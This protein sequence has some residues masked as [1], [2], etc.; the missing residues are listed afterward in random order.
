MYSPAIVL[1]SFAALSC[2]LFA[3]APVLDEPLPAV[4]EAARVTPDI[5]V[6]KTLLFP[7]TASDADGDPLSYKVTSTNPNIL[8]RAKTGNP[9]LRMSVSHADGG[10]TDPAFTGTM[11]FMLF[12]DWLPITTG[13]VSGM[14]RAGFY[15]NVL[16]HR[17]ADLG[18]G[19]GT[20]GFIFQGGDPLGSGG[21]GPGMVANDPQSAWKFQNEFHAGT[22][23]SGR[24]QLAMANAGTTTGYSLGGNG[25]LIVPDY[26]DTNGSQFFITDGQPRH[27]DFKHNIFG[28]L[29]RGWE[30]LP[31]LKATKTVSSRPDKDLRILTAGI[32]RNETDAVLVL[33][34]KA[35]GTATISITVCDPSGATATKQF[36]V[37]A[38]PDT[39][40]CNPFLRRN[41]PRVTRK[42]VPSVFALEMVDLEFDYLD[43]QH[44]MLPLSATLGPKGSLLTSSGRV[45][46]MQPN[47]AYE[48][49]VNIGLSLRQYDI[50]RGS[51]DDI[52]DYT[53]AYVAVGERLARAGNA[54]IE[55]Q[56]G[57][58]LVNAV[59]GRIHDLDSAGA[60]SNFT[61]K[62]NWGD[63]TPLSTGTVVRE[64]SAPGSTTYAAQGGHTY[65]QPGVYP[66]VVDF[67][68]NN[69]ARTLSYG[70]AIVSAGPLRAVGEEFDLT[71]GRVVNR[72]VATFTDGAAFSPLAYS[73]TVDWGDGVVSPGVIS[74]DAENGQFVVRGTHGYRDSEPFSVRVRIHKQND[75]PANDAIAWTTITPFFTAPPHLPPFPHG[76]LTVAWNS[77]PN[78]THS[79]VPGPDYQVKYTGTFVI[80]NTGNRNLGASS[81]RFWVS[82]DR[83]L[84]TSGPAK[85][86]PAKINSQRSLGIIPFPAG[87]GG[88][89]QFTITIPKGEST[90]RKYLIGEAVY[91]QPIADADGSGKYVVTGPLP[92]SVLISA[93]TGMIT[94]EFGGTATFTVSFDTPPETTKRTISTITPGNP[95]TVKT[96]EPHGF[97]SGNEIR[98]SGVTGGTPPINGVYTVT[99]VNSDTFTVP[100]NVTE[101]GTG[102]AAQ[103]NPKVTIPVESS[104]LTEGTVLP[105]NLIFD[106][107]NWNVPQTVTIKGV[108]DT[109]ADGNKNYVIRLKAAQSPDVLFNGFDAGEVSVTNVDNEPRP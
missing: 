29:L 106:P 22:I 101:A 61:A 58:A 55:A 95:V 87:A 92:P 99:V 86:T 59:A 2:A 7:I 57:V 96:A 12:R 84:D 47:A 44:S 85:D 51:F 89:G 1:A 21:G 109:V 60:P 91:R 107:D 108:D 17:V 36:L 90:G 103:I 52:S 78:K 23:F 50:A 3:A 80:I 81:L 16:F 82:N 63:G 93:R 62:I 94:T 73:A 11:D 27:L 46:Q 10:A 70:T 48:G 20:T 4:G 74:H 72:I 5:P 88:S 43:A 49:L 76:K 79:G 56:P 8:V 105:A 98:I 68:G 13:Y 38:V 102:G 97:S 25:T 15:N 35:V 77:G 28:Q 64:S 41:T 66:L 104:V 14:A 53:N 33:S 34:A 6:G 42:D 39:S 19:Q 18:G 71:S 31:L 69:G 100:L 26:L 37:N 75:A 65:A 67:S 32:V 45:V 30:M 54:I 9:V 40:N 83:V 24:G